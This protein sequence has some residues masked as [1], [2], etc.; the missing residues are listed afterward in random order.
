MMATKKVI[1]MFDTFVKN[2]AYDELREL[3]DTMIAEALQT[4]IRARIVTGIYSRMSLE[5]K[6]KL[7]DRLAASYY[8]KHGTSGEF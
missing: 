6:Q 7:Y 2:S 5:T 1:D 8:I 4:D 3:R